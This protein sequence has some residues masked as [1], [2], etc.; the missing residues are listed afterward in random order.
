ME[1][2]NFFFLEINVFFFLTSHLD[3][4]LKMRGMWAESWNV[5]ARQLDP[6][7]VC[8]IMY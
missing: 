2:F 5:C 3:L 7:I 8:I 4:G 1:F 6:A